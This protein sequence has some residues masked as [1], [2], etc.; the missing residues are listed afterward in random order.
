MSVHTR[1][2]EEAWL[3]IQHLGGPVAQN[4]RATTGGST[5]SMRSIARSPIFMENERV[6]I[7]RQVLIDQ[8]EWAEALP[9][10]PRWLE[11]FREFSYAADLMTAESNRTPVREA[12][13]DATARINEL[14]AAD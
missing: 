1:H 10:H 4:L 9:Y 3:L 13:R 6:Q 7:N 11:I 8:M 2:P 12:L 14:L 5:P